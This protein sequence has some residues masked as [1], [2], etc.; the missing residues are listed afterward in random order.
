MRKN[1]LQFLILLVLCILIQGCSKNQTKQTNLDNE[2]NFI[3]YEQY[4]ELFSDL[5]ESFLPNDCVKLTE[6][7]NLYLIAIDKENS[8]GKR[9]FL[10]LDGEQSNT[11]TQQSLCYESTNKDFILYIDLIYLNKELDNDLIYWNS[12]F[13]GEFIDKDLADIYRENILSF[14]N[15]L[16]KITLLR[17]NDSNT[18]T[19]D[20]FRLTTMEIVEYLNSYDFD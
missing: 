11:P 7:E 5:S 16:V 10:T 19:F 2:N 20:F 12:G 18:S 15:I 8:F 6:T 4:K 14:H 9:Q 13:A 17:K 1:I 3:S